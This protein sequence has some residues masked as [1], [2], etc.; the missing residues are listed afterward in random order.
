M[1][2]R[3]LGSILCFLITL[4]LVLV[5]CGG[6]TS[7]TT[8]TA[9][10]TPPTPTSPTATLPTTTTTPTTSTPTTSETPSPT[11][12]TST[13]LATSP[14]K[15]SLTGTWTGTN[16]LGQDV[17]GILSVTVDAKGVIT[18]TFEGDFNGSIEGDI[19]ASGNLRAVGSALVGGMNIEITWIGT[20]TLS[21]NKLSS[22]GTWSGTGASGTYT[23]SGTT[24]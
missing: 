6:Q 3:V 1:K 10:T 16:P 22:E 9:S 2:K 4:T 23:C 13:T 24:D 17:G 14:Y 11:L 12:T 8:P 18:G 15:G 7:T 21:G 20:V 19:D 5:S